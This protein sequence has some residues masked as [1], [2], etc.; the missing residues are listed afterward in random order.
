VKEISPGYLKFLNLDLG[1]INTRNTS[2]QTR[3]LLNLD[4]S[5]VPTRNDHFSILTVQ[6]TRVVI[7]IKTQKPQDERQTRSL[8]I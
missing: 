4:V 5:S 2:T 8:F 6:R 1:K 3:G 7:G